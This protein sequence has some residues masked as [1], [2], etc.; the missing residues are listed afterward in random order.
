MFEAPPAPEFALI[1]HQESWDQISRI[2][3]HLRSAALPPLPLE[4][5]RETVPWIPPRVLT[6]LRVVSSPDGYAV[7]GV[8]VETFLTPE[9]L[10]GGRGHGRS[11]GKVEDGIRAAARSGARIAALGGFTSIL[12][13]A[14]D[15]GASLSDRMALTTGNSLTAA[16]IAKGLERAAG[17]FG[18][19]L[20]GATLLIIGAT[21]DV[22]SAAARYFAGRV[23]RLWLTAR[24]GD[25]LRALAG[26]L[27]G[28]GT[29]VGCSTDPE[30]PL[31]TADLVIAAASLTHPSINLDRCRPEALVCDAGYPKNVRP[32]HEGG[33]RVFHGGMGCITG[34]WT[35]SSTLLDRFY[36][37]PSTRVGHGCLLEGIVLAMDSRFESFS[38][39]RGRITPERMEE[40]WNMARKHG[41]VLAPFFDHRGLWAEQ[42]T[43]K[44][45]SV[46]AAGAGVPVGAR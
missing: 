34:G 44:D 16:F 33:P 26:T 32:A 11:L 37:F 2:V 22:G 38:R 28:R 39:G 42:C 7:S 13:E 40:I 5:L 46:P 27:E 29:A 31:P 1:G 24:R 15:E 43:E 35:S 4:T 3:H 12:L 18:I 45:D 30:M 8:Y 17:M 25:R 10:A 21:G 20:A 19:Q 6:E 23:G 36:A 9:E 14:R 41:V